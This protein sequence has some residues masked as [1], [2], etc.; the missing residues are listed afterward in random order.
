[1]IC[2]LTSE[3]PGIQQSN[4]NQ[5]TKRSTEGC[6]GQAEWQANGKKG[7]GR[8]LYMCM[9]ITCVD[10]SRRCG[11]FCKWRALR[12]CQSQG[13]FLSGVR[14]LARVWHGLPERWHFI[15]L[16]YDSNAIYRAGHL[17]HQSYSANDVTALREISRAQSTKNKA[18][19]HRS[20]SP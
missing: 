13:G 1:M 2:D 11:P 20:L 19:F 9:H 17:I 14:S 18:V 15:T 10:A 16:F 4:R 8:T 12:E 5:R 7:I 3:V 6:H